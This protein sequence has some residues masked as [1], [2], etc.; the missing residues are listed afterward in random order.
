MIFLDRDVDLLIDAL[1]VFRAVS[2]RLKG[3]RGPEPGCEKT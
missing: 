2:L 3:L 1:I